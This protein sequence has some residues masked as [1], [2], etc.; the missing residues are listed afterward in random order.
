[1]INEIESV[2]TLFRK[3][4]QLTE[5]LEDLE[6]EERK[7]AEAVDYYNAVQEKEKLLLEEVAF[8]SQGTTAEASSIREYEDQQ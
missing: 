8:L 3:Q 1:M 5:Q 4:W 2:D 7:I 6:R